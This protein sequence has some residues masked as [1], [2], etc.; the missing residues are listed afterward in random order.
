MYRSHF[1]AWIASLLSTA[2]HPRHDFGA[3]AM[4]RVRHR[5]QNLPPQFFDPWANW[6]N[7]SE[8]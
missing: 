1:K 4:H 3:H 6:A 2:E 8:G 5:V 7:E